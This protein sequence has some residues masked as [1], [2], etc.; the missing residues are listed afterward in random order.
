MQTTPAG[1]RPGGVGKVAASLRNSNT[2]IGFP[3]D[4]VFLEDLGN[5]LEDLGDG[6]VVQLT[7][8]EGVIDLDRLVDVQQHGH[9][10]VF[11]N[12]V[13]L[14]AGRIVD[15]KDALLDLLLLGE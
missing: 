13:S 3:Y 1:A 6:V 11:F 2:T 10:G 4:L 14:G 8:L 7:L 15:R 9:V 5:V 12:V